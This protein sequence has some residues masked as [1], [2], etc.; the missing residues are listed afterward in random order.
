LWH[1]ANWTFVAWGALHGLYMLGAIWT[2][3]LRG[4]MKRRL[5]LDG[6]PGLR[7]FLQ[8]VVTYHLVLLSWVCFRARTLS[9]AGILL[10][11]M[12]TFDIGTRFP[13]KS[14]DFVVSLGCVGLILL[15]HGLQTRW[16]LRDVIAGWPKP[17]RWSFYYCVFW[18]IIF[19]GKFEG[20]EFIYFQF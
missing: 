11:N 19:L 2:E 4:R 9:E 5:W 14:F 16:R 1:G 15:V 7:R 3:D 20:I 8:A 13:Y 18:M 6:H 12:L 17:L 10:R